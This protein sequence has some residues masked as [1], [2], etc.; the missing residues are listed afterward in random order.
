MSVRSFLDRLYDASG[1]L[2]G[3]C[4]LSVFLV[5]LAQVGGREL[6]MQVPGAD[7]LASWFCAAAAFLALA[8]TFQCGEMVQVGLLMERLGARVR[9]W[10]EG[11]SLVIGAVFMGYVC[12]SATRYCLDSWRTNELPQSGT[13]A[14]PLWIPQSSFAI[15]AALLTIALIDNLVEVMRGQ[16]PAYRRASEASALSARGG[17][18]I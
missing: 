10:F 3:L 18:S 5:V 15:G 13:L 8:H 2:A 7:N 6:G 17:E 1:W 16:I 14:L 11:A 12:V 9:P 4:I